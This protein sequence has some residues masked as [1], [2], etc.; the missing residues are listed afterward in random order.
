MA[1]ALI[2]LPLAQ[3]P[4]ETHSVGRFRAC[5]FHG[6][7]TIRAYWRSG[8]RERRSP[9]RPSRDA[10]RVRVYIYVVYVTT[11]ARSGILRPT[12]FHGMFRWTGLPLRR[13]S[14]SCRVFAHSL[15]RVL[16]CRSNTANFASAHCSAYPAP[17][18]RAPVLLLLL[19]G[20]L[21]MAASHSTLY[22]TLP[23]AAL[24]WHISGVR[25]LQHMHQREIDRHR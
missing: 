9:R 16:H 5:C 18:A 17:S 19:G 6:V 1:A 7:P 22:A 24:S 11:E 21:L 23:H 14:G 3:R 10:T 25:Q 4:D 15:Q 8:S 12:M 20:L 13:W 2:R